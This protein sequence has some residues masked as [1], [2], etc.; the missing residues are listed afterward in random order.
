MEIKNKSIALLIDAENISSNYIETIIDEANKYGTINYRRVY[1]DWTTPQ[2]NPWKT[3]ISEFGLTPVQQYAYTSG[4]NS[5]DFT[6]IIDAMDILYSGKVNSFC[7]VSSDSD[8]TKLVTRLREDNMF[9]FGMGESKT[10][11]S[12]VNSCETFAYLD[13]MLKDDQKVEIAEVEVKEPKKKALKAEPKNVSSITPLR[14]IKQELTNIIDTN[15]E[16]DG[17]AYWSQI[18]ALLRKKFPGFHPRNYG[19]NTTILQF[20]EK[21]KEFEVKKEATVSYIKNKK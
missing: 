8:F 19:D 10:P 1:G 16:D 21:M 5:S 7:I 12:L 17:W 15:L 11:I 14:R 9:V 18:A 20:F 2:L 13:K 3:K 4:K 6:L